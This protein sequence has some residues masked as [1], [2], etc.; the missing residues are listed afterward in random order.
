MR[1]YSNTSRITRKKK[2]LECFLSIHKSLGNVLIQ[3]AKKDNL[4]KRYELLYQKIRANKGQ[5]FSKNK[6]YLKEKRLNQI[7]YKNNLYKNKIS[8]ETKNMIHKSAFEEKY[9]ELYY[10]T[11]SIN[12]DTKRGVN[13]DSTSYLSDRLKKINKYNSLEDSKANTIYEK[14]ISLKNKNG[15]NVEIVRIKNNCPNRNVNSYINNLLIKNNYKN[16]NSNSNLRK[17]FFNKINNIKSSLNSKEKTNSRAR[18]NAIINNYI[19]NQNNKK[20]KKIISRKN[21]FI[22][23]SFKSKSFAPIN[24]RFRNCNNLKKSAFTMDNLNLF[25]QN[26]EK[27]IDKVNYFRVRLNLLSMK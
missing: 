22:Y 18:A 5:E 19:K 20:Q 17:N 2:I 11:T 23:Q 26:N 12:R 16:S 9:N 21:D 3:N 6:N 4:G 14:N 13:I 15:N 8:E 25:E 1:R 7:F 27:I 10:L 24:I